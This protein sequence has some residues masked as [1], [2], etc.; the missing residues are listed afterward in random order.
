MVKTENFHIADSYVYAKTHKNGT[1]CCVLM[2]TMVT[3]KHNSVTLNVGYRFYLVSLD[4]D[5][6]MVVALYE[7]WKYSQSSIFLRVFRAFSSV[8][9]Q[10]P[11]YN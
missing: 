1:Y 6:Q 4:F 8:V 5:A 9:R 10:M 2:A 11:G 7:L 3:L